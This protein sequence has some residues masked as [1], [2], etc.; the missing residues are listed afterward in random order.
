MDL[1][2]KPICLLSAPPSH[3]TFSKMTDEHFYREDAIVE[4]R[5]KIETYLDSCPNPRECTISVRCVD[6]NFWIGKHR[7]LELFDFVLGK[8]LRERNLMVSM[9]MTS[10]PPIYSLRDK[11]V[12][13]AEKAKAGSQIDSQRPQRPDEPNYGFVISLLSIIALG[14]YLLTRVY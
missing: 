2:L 12:H 5:H 8:V 7:Y 3:Y 11:A 10:S 9:V 4:M 6:D 13:A 14:L 1:Y